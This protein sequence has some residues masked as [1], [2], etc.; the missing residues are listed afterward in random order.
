MFLLQLVKGADLADGVRPEVALPP[1]MARFSIGRDPACQW[2]IP[3][4]TLALSARHCEI[5]PTPAGPVL[6]DLSTNGSFVN[7][8]ATRLSGEHLLRDGDRIEFGPYMVLVRRTGD[9]IS[10]PALLQFPP[11]PAGADAS[12]RSPG[13]EETAELRGGDPAAML[14]RSGGVALR[15]GLTELLRSAPPPED[16]DLALTK[17]RLAPRPVA[18]RAVASERSPEPAPTPAHPQAAIPAPAPAPL[19][20]AAWLEALALGLGV[21]PEALAGRDPLQAARQVGAIAGAGVAALQALLSQQAAARRQIGS[22]SGAL[23]PLRGLHLLRLAPTPQAAVQALLAAPGDAAALLHAA[24]SDVAAHEARLLAA[25]RDA[26]AQLGDALAPQALEAALDST[27]GDRAARLW[28]LYAQLWHSL[29]GAPGQPWAQG[30][31][32]A[33]LTHLAAAYDCA[34][35]T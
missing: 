25:F 10:P 6:R 11:E 26:V 34:P 28:Q 19:A 21:P 9:A 20:P 12:A 7:G 5:V 30:F 13:V 2:A 33:A 18:G 14:A 35:R 27:G 17:I 16:P 15:A 31:S 4:R 3:D 1:A 8:S 24:G 29:G 22:R 32:E 23:A